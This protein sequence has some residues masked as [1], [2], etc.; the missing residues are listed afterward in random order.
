MKIKKITEAARGRECTIQLHPYCNGDTST[1]VFCHAPSERKGTG[2]KSPDFW[3][4]FGCSA[5][6]D[7]VDLRF[8]S[9]DISR[10]EIDDGF[11]RGIFRT[12]YILFSEGIVK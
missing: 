1:T 8:I 3:G 10:K 2:L 4:A 5:C 11:I 9:D 7:I 12:Q 6:H